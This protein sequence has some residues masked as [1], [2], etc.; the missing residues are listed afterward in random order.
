MTVRILWDT[1][2]WFRFNRST[3]DVRA[4]SNDGGV[5]TNG[6]ES[7]ANGLLLETKNDFRGKTPRQLLASPRIGDFLAWV[8]GAVEQLGTTP[9]HTIGGRLP[10]G[11]DW[12]T[13]RVSLPEAQSVDCFYIVGIENADITIYHSTTGGNTSWV[14][15]TNIDSYADLEL[16]QANHWSGVLAHKFLTFNAVSRRYWRFDFAAVAGLDFFGL[17]S[18]IMGGL[19]YEVESNLS[20]RFNIAYRSPGASS[21][22]LW[23]SEFRD[24][25]CF[26][27]A[28]FAFDFAPYN[29]LIA[30][31][32]MI[33]ERTNGDPVAIQYS[34]ASNPDLHTI[35]GVIADNS[36]YEPRLIDEQN[37]IQFRLNEL[38]PSRDK[39]YLV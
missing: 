24:D 6:A 17:I 39:G 22:G 16:R 37:N 10:A 33:Y 31:Q 1:D 38:T 30:L 15:L 11:E 8:G 32:Q 27:S 21:G 28:P 36:R 13:V 4:W 35:Y 25:P 5:P 26:R 9:P 7:N 18:T 2:A 3:G 34:P 23:H 29:D 19:H 14:E 20:P 12:Y